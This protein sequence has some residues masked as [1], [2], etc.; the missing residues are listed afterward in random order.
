MQGKKLI[1]AGEGGILSTKHQCIFEQALLVGHFNKRAQQQ[2]RN[3]ENSK[4]AVTGNGLK[5]RINPLGAAMVNEQLKNNHFQNMLA[6]RREVAKYIYEQIEDNS[7]SFKGLL[8]SPMI[9]PNS[10]SSFYALPI[11]FNAKHST[12]ALNEFV[13]QL[14]ECGVSSADVPAST[15]PL[16]KHDLFKNHITDDPINPMQFANAERF[17]QS[18][19]KIDVCYGDER[20]KHA[21]YF[22]NALEYVCKMNI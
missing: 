16:N 18:M 11:L 19:F 2:I 20:Q 15:C 12:C 8:S 21:D 5:L 3:E 6:E 17:A 14:N 7:S 10:E 22:L 9:P 1:T 4:Y 13:R